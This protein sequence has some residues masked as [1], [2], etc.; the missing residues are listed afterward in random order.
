MSDQQL[1]PLGVD[2]I[3][4]SDSVPH[5]SLWMRPYLRTAVGGQ[6]GW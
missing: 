5:P 4:G 1:R 2:Y 3:E 6:I